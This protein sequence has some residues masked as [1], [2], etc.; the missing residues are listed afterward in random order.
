[1]AARSITLYRPLHPSVHRELVE[2]LYTSLP[3]ICAS[4]GTAFIGA[5]ALA[6]QSGDRGYAVITV[7]IGLASLL[8]LYWLLSYP[9][10]RALDHAEILK[11][12]RRYGIGGSAFGFALGLLSLRAL[13]LDDAPGAWIAFGLAL[14]FSAGMVSRAAVRPWIV[15]VAGAFLL[16]PI[17]LGGLMR[18]EMPYRLGA[19]MLILFWATMREASRHLS[20]TFV[21]RL[22]AK[23]ELAHQANHDALTGLPNRLA[24]SSAFKP[25]VESADRRAFAVIALDLDGFKPVNDRFGHP[26]GD[27]LLRAVAGRLRLCADAG[28]LVA[29]VGGDEFMVLHR[30]DGA[31]ADDAAALHLARQMV[32][33][34]GQPF[35]IDGARLAIGASAGILLSSPEMARQD[36]ESLLERADEALYGAKRAGGGRCHWAAPRHATDGEM[37]AA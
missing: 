33:A 27:A 16:A 25:A 22:E 1:M 32:Q 5:F 35:E 31:E 20:T 29:R 7:L 28:A 10:T 12:E 21:E 30:F 6:L 13:D 18:P 37:T 34:L 26:V 14:A 24:F 15:L 19:L 2:L 8:R 4:S 17:I 9:R 11:W 23:R 36:W 3:Q